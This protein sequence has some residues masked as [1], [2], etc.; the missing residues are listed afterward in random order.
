VSRARGRRI[1]LLLGA[2]GI[3]A[4][5]PTAGASRAELE[6]R[7]LPP[8]LALDPSLVRFFPDLAGASGPMLTVDYSPDRTSTVWTVLGSRQVTESDRFVLALAGNRTRFGYAL[9]GLTHNLVVAFPSGWGAVLGVSD[10]YW[11]EQQGTFHDEP[12][13][14][15]DSQSFDIVETSERELRLGVGRSFPLRGQRILELGIGGT[16]YDRDVTVDSGSGVL[17]AVV[18]TE[19][20]WKSNPGLAADLTL[21]TVTPDPGFQ[22][23]VRVFYQDM[24]WEPR[25]YFAPRSVGRGGAFQLGWRLRTR[26]LDDFVVG[27]LGT[28][29]RVP[30]DASAGGSGSAAALD[31]VETTRFEYGAFVS[32][33]RRVLSSLTLRGGILGGGTFQEDVDRRDQTYANGLRVHSIEREAA[34]SV[35]SP[36]VFLGA[37][38]AFKD[39]VVD[40]RIRESLDLR[41]PIVRWAATLKL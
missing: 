32:G 41:T 12:P 1:A 5:A 30:G 19:L 31:Q 7:A 21:R 24:N 18:V 9:D 10:N 26:S 37:S 35:H 28:W 8:L 20:G 17:G 16:Y 25:G 6:G 15:S 39:L 34:G 3:L 40:A 36:G 2:A 29:S 23:A 38:W 14:G 13:T 22:G 27:F 11:K 4:Q 33:E